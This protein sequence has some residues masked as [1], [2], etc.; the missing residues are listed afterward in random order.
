MVPMVAALLHAQSLGSTG[1][2]VSSTLFLE[3]CVCQFLGRT[4]TTWQAN[5]GK[6]AWHAFA[7]MTGA[8]TLQFAVAVIGWLGN[9]P[10]VRH[11][12]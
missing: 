6:P 12:Q 10:K 4:V 1:D 2:N 7:F 3:F 9:G 5:E 8:A 11:V